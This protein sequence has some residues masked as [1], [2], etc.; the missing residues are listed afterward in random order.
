MV[1]DSRR[2]RFHVEVGHF[3]GPDD[4]RAAFIF[5]DIHDF[6]KRRGVL[7]DVVAVELDRIKPAPAVV[8]RQVPAAADA[9][10][11]TFR[12]HDNE[13][14][15]VNARENFSRPVRRMI[16]NDNDIVTE[17]AFLGQCTFNG[18]RNGPYPVENRN[19][20]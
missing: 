2:K 12:R 3:I 11:P 15:V 16:V 5:E 8:Y 19:D 9:K 20:Y 14:A 18:V 17:A 1:N 7:V 10:V 13:P 4:H 6:L